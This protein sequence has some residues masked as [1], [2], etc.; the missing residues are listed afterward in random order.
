MKKFNFYLFFIFFLLSFLIVILV[1]LKLGQKG[2]S[3]PATPP[4]AGQD[5]PEQGYLQINNQKIPVEIARTKTEQERGL[6]GRESL[7]PGTGMLF[8]YNQPDYRSFWMKE[9][10]FPLDFI[11]IKEGKIVAITKNI[12]PQDFQPP[13]ALESPKSVDQV[14]E[15][16][17]GEIKQLN[18]KIGNLT[19]LIF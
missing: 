13:Q 6:S 10:N 19:E 12:T 11:W 15:L 2:E 18:L 5:K 4:R 14:L 9:M 16:N 1:L 17:T 3:L 8:I 7:P